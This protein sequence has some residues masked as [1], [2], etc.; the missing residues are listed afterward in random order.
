MGSQCCKETALENQMVQISAESAVT[1]GVGFTGDPFVFSDTKVDGGPGDE[2]SSELTRE[3]TAFGR[4]ETSVDRIHGCYGDDAKSPRQRTWRDEWVEVRTEELRLQ[5]QEYLAKA[6]H[7]EPGGPGCVEQML[8]HLAKYIQWQVDAG[9][10]RKQAEAYTLLAACGRAALA[11]ALRDKS[12]VYACSQKLIVE[13]LKERAGCLSEPAPPAYRNLTGKFGLA[14]ED[15]LWELLMRVGA[16]GT[17]D[18]SAPC[19]TTSAIVAG[20]TGLAYFPNDLGFYVGVNRGGKVVYEM[21]DSDIVCFQ[22]SLDDSDG[23]HSLIQAAEG[24]Y[25]LPPLA[26]VKLESVQASGQWEAYGKQIKRR[27]FTVSVT[28]K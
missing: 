27:L 2:L 14:S 11:R 16:D 4:E 13:V 3:T 17:I 23:F 25:D 8:Q 22:S 18:G 5:G 28:Y 12:D 6:E 26:T 7:F 15:P 20:Y 1:D 19:F 21:Q 10:E 9:W 24:T